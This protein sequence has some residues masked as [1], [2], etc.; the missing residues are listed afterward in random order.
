MDISEVSR[1][2]FLLCE[3]CSSLTVHTVCVCSKQSKEQL[4]A[5][6]ALC[7]AELRAATDTNA[8]LCCWQDALGVCEVFEQEVKHLDKAVSKVGCEAL[9]LTSASRQETT[10]ERKMVFHEVCVCIIY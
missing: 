4:C 2:I 8:D 7:S 10:S 1:N 9:T 6:V 5:S 3:T